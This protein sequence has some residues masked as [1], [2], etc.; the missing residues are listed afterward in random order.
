VTPE[1]TTLYI[2][3]FGVLAEV[4]NPGTASQKW[5]DYM[6]VGNAKV[7]MR[8]LQVASETLTT[9][10]FHTDHL[11]SISVIT[12]ENS[13]VVERLSYDAWGKRRNPN[14]TDDTTGSITSQSTR[15]FTGEEQLSIGGLV[16]LNG[17]V[18][19]PLLARF[20]S[21]DPTVTD[22]MN[23]QGWNRYSYVGNDPL[24]FTDPNG[25]NWF[26]N[27]FGWIGKAFTAIGNFIKQNGM[28]LLQV[29]LNAALNFVTAG[30][31]VPCVAAVSAAVVTGISGGNLGQILKAAA[32]AAV[33]TT[34]F[35]GIGA[36]PGLEAASANPVGYAAYVAE[37]AAVGCASSVASGGSC[38]SG[39]L[40]AGVGAAIS[41]V[42]GSVF[43]SP[44]HNV[45]DLIGGTLVQ[46]TAG[47]L[48][49]VAGGGKFANGAVTAGFQYLATL[50]VEAAAEAQERAA[51]QATQKSDPMDAMGADI[52]AMARYPIPGCGK[53]GLIEGGG[54]GRGIG[55]SGG[56]QPT[57]G[58]IYVTP[59]GTAVTTQP[60]SYSKWDTSG[61]LKGVNTDVTP[62]EFGASLQSNGYTATTTAG[63]NG[64][65]TVYQN[66]TSTYTVYTRSST[67]QSG[68]QYIG[69]N[70]MIKFNL[71]K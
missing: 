33:T 15:G 71:G 63:T 43:K 19:D 3:G 18:Y 70:G 36:A 56:G 69:P 45:E 40:A 30:A 47:G 42:T 26:S 58:P 53:D 38:K 66:G 54:G 37:N 22:P 5:T 17:R 31:C 46:A 64:S 41:P 29:A 65:V 25:F 52:C 24:A 8:S 35:Q 6:S 68:A 60:G 32:I 7:G 28:A 11:G 23:M 44:L 34:A 50:S 16:H 4:T 51:L 55:G 12:D 1:G 14:G 9:R 39:A 61:G 57:R 59:N 2:G 21:A 10:Y 27:A 48:A 67:G 20:T 49:S 62:A 13:L